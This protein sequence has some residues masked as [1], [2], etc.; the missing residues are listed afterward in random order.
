M[1]TS[2]QLGDVVTVRVKRVLPFGLRVTL[3][4]GQPGLIR[5][6]E[7]TWSTS[8]EHDRLREQYTAGDV[9]QAVVL[10]QNRQKQIELSLRLVQNDP[11]TDLPQRYHLGQLANGIVT[12]IQPYGVFLEIEP[13]VVGLLHNSR[14]PAWPAI[15]QTDL[16]WPGD[17][18]T[19]VIDEID[20]AQRR[21]SF[22]LAKAV[23]RR[24]ED[25]ATATASPAKIET[26]DRPE[27]QAVSAAQLPLQ[28]W[29]HAQPQ[30]IL[31]VEDDALQRSAVANW[32]RN[33]G[34][35]VLSAESAEDALQLLQDTTPNIILTDVG[36]PGQNGIQ[37]VRHIQE[38]WPDIRHVIMTDWARAEELSAE[39][40]LLRAA[41]VGLL[42]KPFLPDELL[43]VLMPRSEPPPEASAAHPLAPLSAAPVE[44]LTSSPVTRQSLHRLLEE[45]RKTVGAT[46]AVL[47]ALEPAHQRMTIAAES[48]P[49]RLKEAALLRVIYTPVRDVAEGELLIH[50]ED[51][52]AV[53]GRVRYLRPL[54][55]FQAC[56]G[57][58]VPS[59][60]SRQYALFLF[61]P[62]PHAFEAMHERHAR[63]YA[64]AIGAVL[65]SQ[66]LRAHI[67]EMQRLA[68]LGNL[69]RALVHE[70]NHQL[71]PISFSIDALQA[72]WASLKQE[73]LEQRDPRLMADQ[74]QQAHGLLEVLARRIQ[75][76]LHTAS[77]FRDVTVHSH[78]KMLRL[79]RAVEEV[80]DL[81]KEHAEHARVQI[82]VQPVQGLLFTRAQAAQVQQ[83]LLNLVLNAIQ[84]IALLRPTSGGRVLIRL[85]QTTRARQT[86][87]QI[88]I[89]D[90]G[91]GIHWRSWER[92]F[93][94]GFTTREEEG[95][96]LGLYISRSLAETMG[97]RIYVAKS[98]ILWGS[99][100]VIELPFRT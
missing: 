39:L 94:P 79:D 80:V 92:I 57:V 30:S 64:T 23:S 38:R 83:I 76:L 28:L 95:S 88:G 42:I 96:G 74:L 40:K 56:I 55:E 46:K 51:A 5:D 27:P 14:L 61:H 49:A 18:V 65:D 91:P 68:I 84:Q 69:T 15:N 73:A 54:L 7:L 77:L 52:Q 12:G 2:P 100:F 29:L 70:L 41:G 60:G 75:N 50:I 9:L 81:I 3:D 26:V 37:A 98:D 82:T 97:G 31:V 34:Q 87:L 8:A 72:H 21:L 20:V 11:W 6:R 44:A 22:S 78:E 19:A 4:D 32:L 90:D 35:H 59:E 48:G 86:M 66:E 43:S 99:T 93:E 1:P 62:R 71:S 58:S 53:E 16:F 85:G 36:L 89:E 63:V 33:A 24:W 10:G 67:T 13:G 25:A 45:A 47:F 17:H